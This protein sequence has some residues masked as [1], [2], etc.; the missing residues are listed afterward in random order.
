[1]ASKHYT[2]Y[3]GNKISHA[4]FPKQ[5]NSRKRDVRKRDIQVLSWMCLMCV[6]TATA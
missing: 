1:M 2:V 5:V 6:D 4:N 3:I